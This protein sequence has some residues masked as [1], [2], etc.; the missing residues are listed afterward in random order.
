[1]STSVGTAYLDVTAT[2]TKALAALRAL[3]PSALEILAPLGKPIDL[4]INA[5]ALG[6]L[7]RQATEANLTWKQFTAARMAEYMQLEGSNGAAM[8]RM[9][10]EWQAYKAQATGAAQSVTT[11]IAQSTGETVSAVSAAQQRINGL[12]RGLNTEA[13]STAKNSATVFQNA[14][15]EEQAQAQNYRQNLQFKIRLTQQAAREQATAL[16]NEAR[17][18]ATA[19]SNYRQTLQLNL[20]MKKEAIAAEE[21]A[22]RQAAQNYRQTLALNGRLEQ[23]AIRAQTL[24]NKQAIDGV[25]LAYQKVRTAADKAFA[26]AHTWQENRD[27]AVQYTQG[28]RGVE[29][30]LQKVQQRAGLTEAELT[31]LSRLEATLARESATLAGKVNPL[32][33]SGNISN[34][35]K[36]F[37]GLAPVLGTLSPSLGAAAAPL[38]LLSGGFGELKALLNPVTIGIGL[39]VVA[40]GAIVVVLKQ[41]VDAAADFQ[42]QMKG[43]QSTTEASNGE[44]TILGKNLLGLTRLLPVTSEQLTGVA[45]NA[46][47]FGVRGNESITNF[48]KTIAQLGVVTRNNNKGFTDL[49]ALSEQLVKFLNETGSTAQTFNKDLKDV[50]TTL[51]SVDQN[52]A[53]TITQTLN[54]A[55]FMAAGSVTLGLTRGQIIGLSGALSGLGAEAESGGSSVIRFLSKMEKTSQ[56]VGK[57][58]GDTI[59]VYERLT[60]LGAKAFEELVRTNPVAALQKVSDGLRQVHDQGGSVN[61]VLAALGITNIRDIKLLDQLTIG[62]TKI[63]QGYK[64]QLDALSGK[65]SLDQKAKI[66]TDN[67]R[68]S[69]T[70]LNS[71]IHEFLIVIGTPFLGAAK[72]FTDFL[73]N[74]VNALT[75][76]A[77]SALSGQTAVSD[78]S[79]GA[80]QV[81]APLGQVFQFV[82]GAIQIAWETI[83]K[84]VLVVAY[85][86]FITTFSAIR[87]AVTLVGNVIVGVFK[88]I[89]SF[90]SAVFE[91]IFGGSMG[92]VRGHLGVT[93]GSVSQFFATVRAYFLA[94]GQV[95]GTLPEVFS[96]MGRSVGQILQ[97]VGKIFAG[98][99][100]IAYDRLVKPI[101]PIVEAIRSAFASAASAIGNVLTGILNFVVSKFQPLV[102][103]LDSIGVSIANGLSSLVASAAQG[104][105]SFVGNAADAISA[106][107]ATAAAAAKAAADQAGA[108]TLITS[109]LKEVQAG[110]EGV[111]NA[112]KGL[113]NT[114]A[115]A[116]ASVRSQTQAATKD[117]LSLQKAVTGVPLAVTVPKRAPIDLSGLGGGAAGKKA[118]AAP[119]TA[120]DIA[121]LDTYKKSLKEMSLG[122]L[123]AAK[124]TAIHANDKKKVTAIIAELNLRTR[125]GTAETKKAATAAVAASKKEAAEAKRAADELARQTEARRVLVRELRQSIESFQLLSNQHKV[126]AQSQ[127]NFNHRIEDFQ[128]RISK[129]PPELQKGTGAL[130]SQ[131]QQLSKNAA[132]H[133]AASKLADQQA[134]SARSLT[135]QLTDLNDRFRLQTSEGKVTAD[136]LLVYQQRLAGLGDKASKLPAILQGVLT[137]LFVQGQTLAVTGKGVV[138]YKS[139]LSNLAKA[140]KEYTFAELE[141]ARARVVASGG[142]QK[143]LDLIDAQIKK[144]KQLTGAQVDQADAESRLATAGTSVSGLEGGRDNAL[145]AAKGNLAEI[146]RLQVQYGQQIQDAQETQARAQADKDVQDVLDKYQ[147]L[148]NLAGISEAQQL[149]LESDRAD[150]VVA[151]ND[152][153]TNTLAKNSSDRLSAETEAKRTLDDRLRTMDRETR[154]TIRKDLLD[155]LKRDTAALESAQ[156]EQLDA[157]DLTEAEKLAIRQRYQPLLLAQKAR[158]MEAS[159]AIDLQAESDRY[160]DQ[161]TAAKLDGTFAVQEANLLRVHTAELARINRDYDDQGRDYSLGVKRDT[162]KQ[163]VAAQKEE[164]AAQLD[165]AKKNVTDTFDNLDTTVE[166]QRQSAR[167]TLSFWRVTYAAMGLAGKAAVDEITAALKKLDDAGDKARIDAAKLVKTTPAELTQTFQ[168]DLRKIGKVEDASDA[169]LKAEDQFTSLKDGYKKNLEDVEA[170]LTQFAE[171]RDADLTPKEASTKAGLL[172]NRVLYQ[173]FL[174][175][176]AAAALAAG[177]KAADDFTA[178]ATLASK[179]ADLALGLAQR[180][181]GLIT[182]Q[183][184]QRQLDAYAVYMRSRVATFKA[185]SN[186]Q[187][188]ASVDAVKAEQAA[189]TR[190][191][192]QADAEANAALARAEKEGALLT[193]KGGD[194]AALYKAGLKTALAFFQGR[195]DGLKG[196]DD[197]TNAERETI[198]KTIAELNDKILNFVNDSPLTRALDSAAGL[199]TGSTGFSSL[200]KTSLDGLSAYFKAGGS[201]GGSKSV[202]LGAAAFVSGLGAVFQTGDAEM[203]KV[204]NGFVNGVTTVLSKLASGDTFGAILAGAATVVSTIM[205][206]FS[207]G[208]N[209]AKKA[210]DEITAAT[211][212]VK[213]FNLSGYAKTVSAGG[214]FGFL[215]F[216]KSQIDQESIDIAKTLGDSLYS[217]ISTGML[218][219]IKAGKASFGELGI[220]IRASLADQILQGLIDG[221]L[222]STVF[223]ATVQPFLDKYI[224]AMKSGNSQAL[225]E[226]ASGLQGAIV[227]GNGQ[228]QAF[229]Q[230]VLVPTG[231]QLGVFGSTATNTTSSSA[232]SQLGL[233]TAPTGVMA[234]PQYQLEYTAALTALTPVLKQ[235]T[236]ALQQLV[237]QGIHV[238][239]ESA[240]QVL[241][242]SSDLRAHALYTGG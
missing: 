96:E 173:S 221:F 29:T 166:A 200:I 202:L 23:D 240:V 146:Y 52:T 103:F 42:Q 127:L 228:L 213:I 131:A 194:G 68:D 100:L 182:E 169:Q 55:K 6:S 49:S 201:E 95:V 164:S 75:D 158:E 181:A 172:A 128:E 102:S 72:G 140:V 34:A 139:Q 161:V 179:Q 211:S 142:D 227:T 180:E 78:F 204:T 129:L 241:M 4:K 195:L 115:T 222:K 237:D 242:P 33:L 81:L 114:A 197:Q 61:Q 112:Y 54:L 126:T 38:Q 159:R 94:A 58:A 92:R 90:L 77:T 16:Q 235:L 63:A 67:L 82:F 50:A 7:E 26:G 80:Q 207:G 141:S 178:A 223:Q 20:R 232:S 111:G 104:I 106:Q 25:T 148:L 13:A 105:Q 196:S 209:S 98:F 233:A 156:Q 154:D 12:F 85:Q 208:A 225:A 214:F 144:Y 149:Q 238:S 87:F 137:G 39:A 8:T 239:A 187:I 44:T 36:A 150:E 220:D 218:D 162:G 109:G 186:E 57:N 108:T 151:I 155:G 216:K 170:A 84:P 234:A 219:G 192:T 99:A 73:K 27:A 11:A 113:Q 14:A 171:K 110:T 206:I 53:S 51:A 230:N 3:V 135:K 189:T 64:A 163:L 229:Y 134:N 147:K 119:V 101:L 71:G 83:L 176:I 167:N 32:G 190:A 215:G 65:V 185:G 143:K 122:E 2:T 212:G 117:A 210:A 24:A 46:V 217:A 15:R 59:K 152:G 43:I 70:L 121:A 133:V 124:A 76:F 31:K 183:E 9:G 193:S 123:E 79:T 22:S 175:Q 45:R 86:L 1:M 177:K 40:I 231:Q 37:Q 18:E 130:I 107:A 132:L 66:A 191:R 69:Q 157:E 226:A 168:G 136:S 93:V 35:L 118:K 165:A 28:M 91:P 153:L 174:A 205:D 236:P 41:A 203:D 184:Y 188:Q 89:G 125:E 5:A 198:Q 60:G 30:E 74:A 97:G 138:D 10:A 19:A 56:G 88:G 160:D 62:N 48:T 120:A 21:A 47:L 145:A 116:L 17:A 199:F 224:T